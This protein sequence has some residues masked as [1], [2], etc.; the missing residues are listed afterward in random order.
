[1][2]RNAVVQYKLPSQIDGFVFQPIGESVEFI[3]VWLISTKKEVSRDHRSRAQVTY[4]H[5]ITHVAGHVG[6]GS[7]GPGPVARRPGVRK[8]VKIHIDSG[9]VK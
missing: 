8:V 9:S 4:Q 5:V 7:V 2:I 3:L 1:M 6:V